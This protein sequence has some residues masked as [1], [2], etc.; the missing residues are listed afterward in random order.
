[1]EKNQVIKRINELREKINYHNY[2]YYVLDN[3]IITDFEYDKLMEELIKLEEKYPDLVTEDSP[4]QRVGGE[5]LTKFNQV[6]HTVPLL[7]LANSYNEQDLLDFDRRIK[8]EIGQDVEYV[9]E[10]KIDGL[11]V[12]LKYEN[13][14]FVR[15]ATRGDGEIGEDITLNLKTIKSI[16]LRLQKKNNIEVRGEVYIPKKKFLELNERQEEMGLITF[17]NPRNAAAGSL[18]QLDPKVTASRPL[19]IFVFEILFSGEKNIAKH[20]EGLEYLK[21]LGFKTSRYKVCQNI[22]EVIKLCQEWQEKRHELSFEIDGLVIKVNRLKQREELG[23]TAKSPRWAIA[24][25]FPAEEKETT[26]KDIIV[27]VGRTGAIT[28]T[29]VLEPVRVAGSVVSR[30]TLHNQDFIDEKDIRIGDRVIIHK[31]GDV[32]PEVVRVLKDKR[33]GDERIFKLPENC[34]ECNEPTVRLEGEAALRCVNIACPAQLRRGIIHFVSREAMNIEG[35]GEAV[36][37]QLLE[38]DLIRDPGD[39][40]YLKGKREELIALERMGEKSVQNLL[41]AIED[42]KSNDLSKVLSALGIRLV[43]AKAALVLAENFG[44]MEKLMEASIE[45]LTEI[46]EIGPKMAESIVAFFEE[47]SNKAVIDKLKAAGV[48]MLSLKGDKK[49]ED[50]RLEGVTFVLTG[51]LEGFTRN[52]AKDIIENLG[53][54]VTGSVSKKTDYVLAGENPGSKLDKAKEL[55]IKIIDE[56]EFRSLVNK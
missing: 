17:A 44:S 25:K 28:P 50:L 49:K 24:Y 43:G 13:G 39:L 10:F 18:R 5:P 34:P 46:D 41:K 30:A 53:G 22:N 36:V 4:T 14:V 31:A 12:A 32:I 11:S 52:E 33:K 8:R 19:D 20:S 9:V 54:K 51:T 27:Q 42:S 45:E 38:N 15:G 48:N 16:P 40:Y 21:E 26:V 47:E 56:E 23:A 2:Q 55:G 35:L 37:T 3:P 29:A 1:M 7:S 6:N